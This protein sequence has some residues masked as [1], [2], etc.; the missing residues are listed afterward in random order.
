MS[1]NHLLYIQPSNHVGNNLELIKVTTYVCDSTDSMSRL[2]ARRVE[3]VHQ[4]AH[5]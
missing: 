1:Y 2:T 3:E 4:G 5:L